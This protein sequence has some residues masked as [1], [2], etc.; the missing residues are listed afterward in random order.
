MNQA[1]E[2]NINMKDERERGMVNNQ[3]LLLIEIFTFSALIF[4][5]ILQTVNKKSPL[6]G[7]FL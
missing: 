1:F 4:E 2:S 5:P 3:L 6:E 7:V